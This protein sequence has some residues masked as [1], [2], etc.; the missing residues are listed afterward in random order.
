[1]NYELIYNRLV[2]RGKTVRPLVEG[3]GVIHRHHIVPRHIGGTDDPSNITKLQVKEHWLAH[4]LLH[5]IYGRYQDQT[6]WRM[7]RGQITNPWDCAEYRASM[8][9]KVT[10][11]LQN[12]DREKAGRLAGIAAKKILHTTIHHPEVR[13]RAK[14]AKA[15]WTQ[16]NPIKVAEIAAY[17]HTEDARVNMARSKSKYIIISPTGQEYQSTRE[18]ALATGDKLKNITNWTIRGHYGWSRRLKVQ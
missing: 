10:A 3:W 7:L 4:R 15:I 17:M 14:L 5:K 11:N 13:Q 18:A 6:A 16:D 9:V 12:V 2:E 1:M 8:T